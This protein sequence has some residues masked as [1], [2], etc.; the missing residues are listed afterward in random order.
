MQDRGSLLLGSEECCR[1]LQQRADRG[2]EDG[3]EEAARL[4]G[5][6]YHC[7]TQWQQLDPAGLKTDSQRRYP[8]R[9]S[10]DDPP[11]V[12]SGD[13]PG[14]SRTLICSTAQR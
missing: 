4:L 5:F 11:G 8:P 14:A 6:L 7:A 10:S 13:R 1:A 9:T 3:F 2:G 12:S